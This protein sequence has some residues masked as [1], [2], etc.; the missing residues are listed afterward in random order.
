MKIELLPFWSQV[1][2]SGLLEP[3]Q[4]AVV[5]AEV[6]QWKESHF[7]ASPSRASGD[8]PSAAE[9]AA[10]AHQRLCDWLLS[11]RLLTP[12]QIAI[13]ADEAEPSDQNTADAGEPPGSNAAL[14]QQRQRPHALENAL[15]M[16]PFRLVGQIQDW[17][18]P[19]YYLAVP[20][21]VKPGS[22]CDYFHA[23]A[24]LA[25][26][27]TLGPSDWQ[28]IHH[29]VLEIAPALRS[30]EVGNLIVPWAIA[31]TDSQCAIILPPC[32]SAP[33]SDRGSVDDPN[34]NSWNAQT[35]AQRFSPAV[36]ERKGGPSLKRVLQWTLDLLAALEELSKVGLSHGLLNPSC[37]LQNTETR[38]AVLAIPPLVLGHEGLASQLY[39]AS[40]TGTAETIH[41]DLA[42]GLMREPSADWKFGWTPADFLA[43]EQMKSLQN[44]TSASDLYAVGALMHWLLSGTAPATGGEWTELAAKKSATLALSLPEETPSVVAKLIGK[45]LSPEP[46][47][48]P[49]IA[50]VQSLLHSLLKQKSQAPNPVFT[51]SPAAA[52][53]QRIATAWPDRRWSPEVEAIKPAD[54]PVLKPSVEMPM[55]VVQSHRNGD[56]SAE[57]VEDQ[58]STKA[59]E[60]AP[61]ALVSGTSVRRLREER[62]ATKSRWSPPIIMCIVSGF[63][64]LLVLLG[65]MLFP[66]PNPKI[67]ADP[68]LDPKISEAEADSTKDSGTS[69]AKPVGW[70]QQVVAD[71]GRL[72]WE[73]P[74]VG[75]P[76][77]V[78]MV[79]DNPSALLIVHR[80]FWNVP[81][82]DS[83]LSALDGMGDKTLSTAVRAWHE[84]FSVLQFERSLVAQYQSLAGV[85]HVFLLE[86]AKPVQ[87]QLPGWK[88][89]ASVTFPEPEVS[90]D[91]PSPAVEVQHWLLARRTAQ[92]TIEVAWAEVSS[93]HQN[94]EAGL[95]QTTNQRVDTPMLDPADAETT[96]DQTPLQVTRILI[97]NPE[98]MKQAVLQAGETQVAGTM[99]NL[100]RFSD[101]QRHLQLL[102]NPVTVWNA[103]GQDWLGTRWQWLG[104]LVKDRIAAAVRMVYLSVH[105]AGSGETYLEM[106]MIA[107]R[108]Q[109]TGT[110]IAPIVEQLQ[111]M[112][113]EVKRSL[114]D[115]PRVKYWENALLRYDD[116]LEDV[117]RFVR[118]G[119]HDRV[120]TMNAWLR[121]HALDNLLATT[122]LYFLAVKLSEGGDLP[123]L[124]A[125]DS[126]TPKV[127][128]SLEEL[129]QVRRNLEIPEQDLINAL[130]E[131]ESD[132]QTGFP[133]LPFQFSIELD[134]NSLRLEGITQNQK[135]T[136]FK[137]DQQ[138]LA[139]ILTALVLKAN[140]DPAVTSA[141]DPKC[142]LIWL[143]DPNRPDGQIR[144]TT[145][146]A[147]QENGWVL[148]LEVSPE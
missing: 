63:A 131:L 14:G 19:H 110:A 52:A 26:G 99:A 24:L 31:Q 89:I 2:S 81:T 142:K 103:Q 85:D 9:I 129:L 113:R 96:L 57:S 143:I 132:I 46:N 34:A 128:R 50:E 12:Y 54:L 127:P 59:A 95:P 44:T 16:G 53:C 32:G 115:L 37:L 35:L 67:V 72:L 13:L 10:L 68:K 78:S 3:A 51:V 75:L 33:D 65:W 93:R 90:D 60:P 41:P 66:P 116:M 105:V 91:E 69:S 125:N 124:D 108:S 28:S 8:K 109:A 147:A 80:D 58:L 101:D 100:L 136:N 119:Q 117:A 94:L 118:A 83:L 76:V 140:P 43:P 139:E 82:L 56:P 23:G 15:E 48:R 133:G 84:E 126:T 70:N 45:L 1:E 121:P 79:P 107:D 137:A 20:K 122:E 114:L 39:Q 38:L 130:A 71:D 145:R 64:T 22:L 6:G 106:K 120:P 134:G 111:T 11:H 88:L 61:T 123:T 138:T 29:R 27:D 97:A 55:I 42:A 112:P 47:T 5:R 144:I 25:F 135:I 92:Q 148:P 74:T 36:R 98:L 17:G 104:Q 49:Q 62:G 30:A 87:I 21:L 146:V 40:P 7:Q 141:K 18:L 77:A 86:S 102:I 4:M 73:S